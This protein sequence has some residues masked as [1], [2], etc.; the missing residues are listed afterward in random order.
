MKKKKFTVGLGE[1]PQ[2]QQRA[3]ARNDR[4]LDQRLHLASFGVWGGP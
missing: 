4:S 3:A 2:A 1:E